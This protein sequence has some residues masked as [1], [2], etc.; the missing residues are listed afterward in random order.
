MFMN[1]LFVKKLFSV[2][3]SIIILTLTVGC[4]N[5]SEEHQSS[6]V[7][8]TQQ[9]SKFQSDDKI[10]TS[11][12]VESSE[13]NS[14]NKQESKKESKQESKQESNKPETS[15][16]TTE[17]SSDT[18]HNFSYLI[19]DDI[20]GKDIVVHV[21]D[22]VSSE[23]Y[24]DKS[25][26]SVRLLC[27]IENVS[28]HAVDLTASEHFELNNNGL[29]ASGVSEYDNTK[30]A[31]GENVHSHVTFEYP[32]TGFVNMDLKDMVLTVDDT[33]V[34]LYFEL[35]ESYP[36]FDTGIYYYYDENGVNHNKM[37][38][39]EGRPGAKKLR[40]IMYSKEPYEAYSYR[41]INTEIED[42]GE[43]LIPHSGMWK[44]ENSQKVICT[45]FNNPTDG[46][47]KE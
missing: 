41:F 20:P 37:M 39:I 23:S 47:I 12:A 44:I 31:P 19:T 35:P 34:S 29:I 10:K 8:E 4:S 42:S 45:L 13:N 7:S 18:N 43:F 11:S 36:Q 30:L 6:A 14:D 16:A 17:V 38:I 5:G 2:L 15:V 26:I 9:E 46:Y 21:V 33:E 22:A 32:D 25:L 27:S 1:K 3:A 28:D 24:L 40:V